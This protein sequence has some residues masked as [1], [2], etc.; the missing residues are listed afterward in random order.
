M[1]QRTKN[2][3]NMRLDNSNTEVILGRYFGSNEDSKFAIDFED[4]ENV[5]FYELNRADGSGRCDR[6]KAS[7]HVG[8]EKFTVDAPLGKDVLVASNVELLREGQLSF[9]KHGKP[10]AEDHWLITRGKIG[11]EFPTAGEKAD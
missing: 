11:R 4:L 6:I 3:N 7:F 1:L 10:E 8:G 9:G 2:P 5:R